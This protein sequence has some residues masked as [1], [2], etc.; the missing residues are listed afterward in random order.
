M[1]LSHYSVF[2]FPVSPSRALASPLDLPDRAEVI[3]RD[4]RCCRS[5]PPRPVLVDLS[6][7]ANGVEPAEVSARSSAPAAATRRLGHCGLPP[8]RPPVA[9]QT[10][11]LPCSSGSSATARSGGGRCAPQSTNRC[12]QRRRVRRREFLER[13]SNPSSPGFSMYPPSFAAIRRSS[14]ATSQVFARR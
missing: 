6:R 11:S 9:P 5:V 10:G 7:R 12:G 2:Y 1:V 4:G 8:A 13:A 3:A 14:S